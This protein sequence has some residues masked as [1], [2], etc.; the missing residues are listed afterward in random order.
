MSPKSIAFG[1]GMGL[2]AIY[3]YNNNVLGIAKMLA[4]PTPAAAR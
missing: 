2:V 4:P 1:I 3:L